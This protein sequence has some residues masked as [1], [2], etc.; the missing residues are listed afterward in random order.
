MKSTLKKACALALVICFLLTLVTACGSTGEKNTGTEAT[1]SQAAQNTDTGADTSPLKLGLY[2]GETWQTQNIDPAWTDP[3]AKKI[4]ELTGI[5]FDITMTKS[6]NPDQ[7]IS[8][9]MASDEIPDLVFK[10]GDGQKNLISGGYVQPLDSLIEQYGPTIKEK[11]SPY[12][13]DWRAEDGK[14][15]NL[16]SWGW[17]KPSKAGLDL[18]PNTLNMRYDILKE[19]GYA[20]LNRTNE[21][22][23]FIT[24]DEYT[25]LLA[26]VKE[27]YPQMIP[28]LTSKTT[29]YDVLLKSF[30]KQ[31]FGD[32]V[33]NA[34]AQYYWDNEYTPDILKFMNNLYTKEYLP[35]GFASMTLEQN[36]NNISTGKVFSTLGM[37]DGLRESQIALS[38]GNDE[39]RMVMFYLAKDSAVK[40]VNITWCFASGSTST[41]VSSKTKNAERIVKFFDWCLTEDASWLLNAGVEEVTYKK[42]TNGKRQPI[43]EFYNGYSVWDVN[44]LKKFGAAT[45]VNIFPSLAGIN[46]E[47]NA[48]DICAQK[49]FEENKW[50]QYN[51]IGWKKH[52][53]VNIVSPFYGQISQS[54]QANAFEAKSKINAYISDRLIK[55]VIAKNPQDCQAEW[56]K[57]KN[58]MKGDG[59][60]TITTAVEQNWN[61]MA[62]A[63]NRSPDATVLTVEQAL[64]E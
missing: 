22:D 56:E 33:Y 30:G 52:G 44:V 4:T 5:S 58:Q 36:Q 25:K 23:G 12:F 54:K 14:L 53:F 10:I 16:G 59:L 24:W 7:E 49:T 15:Y 31:V 21:M 43:D 57:V 45:W 8:I 35:K 28:V 41:M 6:D 2:I 18:Q 38:E 32:A 42:D 46:T 37:I 51:N 13:G 64:V 19:L 61:E 11:L 55:A 48:Y 60:D 1:T 17:T 39:R 63:Y 34:K 40:N 26:Q 62:K 47:G 50:T 29:S 3:V 27:K 20:K 9:M